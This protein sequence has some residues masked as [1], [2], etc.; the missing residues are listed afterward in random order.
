MPTITY[1]SYT[2]RW[3][4]Q[5]CSVTKR[6][7]CHAC[8]NIITYFGYTSRWHNQECS[9]TKRVLCHAC[10]NIF[11]LHFKVAHPGLQCNQESY[12]MPAIAYFSYTLRW[13]TQEC[14]VTKRVLCHAHNNIFRLHFKVAHPGV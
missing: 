3:H 1:F 4:T 9:V 11:R 6:V 10:N 5:E 13:H 7:L 2:L 12:V 8:N 14:S